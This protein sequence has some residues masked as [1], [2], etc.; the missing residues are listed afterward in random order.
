M[1][2]AVAQRTYIH[3][4]SLVDAISNT[5]LSNKTIV[6]ESNKIVEVKDGFSTPGAG[7]RLVDLKTQQ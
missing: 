5:A 7:D 4:G 2:T 6:V 3:C 1:T